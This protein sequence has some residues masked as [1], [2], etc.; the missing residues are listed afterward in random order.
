MQ[1]GVISMDCVFNVANTSLQMKDYDAAIHY[2][3]KVINSESSNSEVYMN[4]A[5]LY[6]HQKE[7]KR[8][9]IKIY[10]EMLKLYPN[11]ERANKELAKLLE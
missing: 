2:Y 7:D 5:L 8:E 9:A 10:K 11:H 6:Q 1:V 4:L 3:K